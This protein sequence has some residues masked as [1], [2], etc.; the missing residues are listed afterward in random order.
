MMALL[1]SPGLVV[2]RMTNSLSFSTLHPKKP[3]RSRKTQLFTQVDTRDFTELSLKIVWEDRKNRCH[4]ETFNLQKSEGK[5]HNY[6]NLQ[7]QSGSPSILT[8][9]VMGIF[10]KI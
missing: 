2:C 9:R 5:G 8:H 6:Y 10:N 3:F 7:G 1:C 4:V